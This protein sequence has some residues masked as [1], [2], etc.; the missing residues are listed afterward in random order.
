MS[1]IEINILKQGNQ[2]KNVISVS[3]FTMKNS[4]RPIEF[5][6]QKLKNFMIRKKTLKG[7]E[8]RIYTDNS[9]KDIA[10]ELADEDT[11]IIQYNCEFFREEDGHTGTFGTIV[12]FLPLF[13]KGLETVWISD[14]DIHPSFLDTKVLS[15]MKSNKCDIFIDSA[16][17]Y[18]RKPWTNVKYPIIAHRFISNIIFPKQMFTRFLNNLIDGKMS[19]L[20]DEINEYNSPL[21]QPNSKFPYGMDEAFLNSS[22]YNSIHRHKLKILF[23]ID[24]FTQN[25][26]V[27]NIERFPEKFT[28][29]LKR[30]YREPTQDLFKKVKDIYK[31]YTPM[32]LDKYPCM[33]DLI[34]KLP[35]FKNT[36][37]T[38]NVIDSSV[39]V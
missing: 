23:R 18:N 15:T 10:L 21:K 39:M 8:T 29:I 1:Q 34:D 33:Q 36:F 6:K 5:Y 38:V 11:T 16:L 3:F 9:G 35:T 22:I 14:I 30:Y 28:N 25:F 32:L 19:T 31:E 17:C 7:F 37:V 27:Y 4:Y 24:Y 26:M 2:F 20:I 12:R 13:E